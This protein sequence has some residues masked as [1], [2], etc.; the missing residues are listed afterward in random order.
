MPHPP[1][2][3]FPPLPLPPPPGAQVWTKPSWPK[4]RDAKGVFLQLETKATKKHVWF[5]PV[6][7]KIPG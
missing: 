1:A 7:E 5:V 4:A 6:Q 3:D 2:P